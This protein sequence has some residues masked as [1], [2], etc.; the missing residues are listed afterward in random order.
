M[1]IPLYTYH[2]IITYV[3]T[4]IYIYNIYN[5]VYACLYIVT[6]YYIHTLVI[7][8]QE[9]LEQ[10]CIHVAE[11]AIRENIQDPVKLGKPGN[12]DKVVNWK[13]TALPG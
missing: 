10:C 11:M 12:T 9:K 2:Y 13:T 4:H 3:H 1:C 7:I 6:S 8:V 5:F